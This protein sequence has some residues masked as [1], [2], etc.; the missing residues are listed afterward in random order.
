MV[1]TGALPEE[2]GSTMRD[3]LGDLHRT[4]AILIGARF[5]RH[6]VGGRGIGHR[7]DAKNLTITQIRKIAQ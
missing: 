1:A 3:D 4:A 5:E 7:A 6:I 2:M